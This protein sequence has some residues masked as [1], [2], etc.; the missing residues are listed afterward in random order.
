M[1]DLDSILNLLFEHRPGRHR[2]TYAVLAIF[3][4]VLIVGNTSL[5]FAGVVVFTAMLLLLI[6]Q[7][8]YP[9][10]MG[11]LIVWIPTTIYSLYLLNRFYDRL[12]IKDVK[13]FEYSEE[14]LF[15]L[16]ITILLP[17]VIFVFGRP[18]K[19]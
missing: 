2:W 5:N 11:W 18:R 3:W 6:L 15:S 19:T 17:V 14:L 7:T 10:L 13:D 12:S 1:D 9:T 4:I 16:A 8:A